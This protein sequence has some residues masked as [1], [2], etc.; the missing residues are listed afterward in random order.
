MIFLLVG[1]FGLALALGGTAVIFFIE[2]RRLE[3]EAEELFRILRKG[4]L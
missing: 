4:Q 3:R 2:D 1:L